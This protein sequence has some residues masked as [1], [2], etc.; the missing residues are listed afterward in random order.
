[1]LDINT[2]QIDRLTAER[3]TLQP[4]HDHA[5]QRRSHWLADHAD[6]AER[7]LSIDGE[8]RARE[9]A[10]TRPPCLDRLARSPAPMDRVLS[11]LE[12]PSCGHDIGLDL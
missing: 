3:D 8:L 4:E 11:A 9:L 7:L 1:M 12:P 5:Q 6:D 10:D 2:R